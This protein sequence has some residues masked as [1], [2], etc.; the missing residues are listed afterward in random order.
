MSAYDDGEPQYRST[1]EVTV[2]IQRNLNAPQFLRDPYTA[3]L[4]QVKTPYGQVVVNTTAIDRDGV[5]D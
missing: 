1:A 2:I 4:D 3:T 5:S